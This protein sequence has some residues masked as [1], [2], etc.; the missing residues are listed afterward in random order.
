MLAA[1]L[2]STVLTVAV[3]FFPDAQLLDFAGPLDVLGALDAARTIL[4]PPPSQLLKF[5]YVGPDRLV[6]PTAGPRVAMDATYAELVALENA[7]QF[8]VVL[9]PGG[10]GTTPR[11]VPPD[12]LRFLQQQAPGAK[13]VMSV[14]TG[15][16]LLA[17]AGLL[18]GKH[19][20]TNKALFDVVTSRSSS[21]IEWVHHAR[22]V[23]DGKFWTS[24]GVTAGLDMTFAW[25]S[26]L[27]GQDVADQIAGVIEH[28]PLAQDDDVFADFWTHEKQ[29]ELAE[30]VKDL[31]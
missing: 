11:I 6:T 8:D 2:A 15:A 17:Q 16:W 27:V 28:T 13:Y 25:V 10:W 30:Q 4:S 31:L 7:T 14:C 24:S 22:W 29:A 9:V 26:Q 5:T 18:D 21:H 23:V 3:C 20:T 1:Q 12:L 19:A